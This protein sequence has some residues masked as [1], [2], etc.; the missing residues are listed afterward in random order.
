MSG[1]VINFAIQ[2]KRGGKERERERERVSDLGRRKKSGACRIII[3]VWRGERE[4]N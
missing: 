2:F 1:I 3:I 4:P